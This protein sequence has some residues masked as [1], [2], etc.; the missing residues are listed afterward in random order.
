MSSNGWHSSTNASMMLEGLIAQHH[1]SE[2]ELRLLSCACV[3][4]TLEMVESLDEKT[5]ADAMLI[6]DFVERT[7]EAV[8]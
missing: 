6:I 1:P 7:A 5:R 3:R 2:Q 8:R 4:L